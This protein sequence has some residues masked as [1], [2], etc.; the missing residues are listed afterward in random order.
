MIVFWVFDGLLLLLEIKLDFSGV[1]NEER[2][3]VS[4]MGVFVN[5]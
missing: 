5:Y 2:G 4:N 1:F 3:L